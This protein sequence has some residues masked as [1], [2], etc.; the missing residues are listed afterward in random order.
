MGHFKKPTCF[1]FFFEEM[2]NRSRAKKAK[3]FGKGK[4]IPLQVA[5][6]VDH[7]LCDNNYSQ[8]RSSFRTEASS[9]ISTSPVQEVPLYF[10]F[11]FLKFYDLGFDF[12]YSIHNGFLLFF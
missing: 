4:V 3:S 12:F 9:L 10:F 2:G 5:F 11:F 1:L 6:I 7:Y 8:T